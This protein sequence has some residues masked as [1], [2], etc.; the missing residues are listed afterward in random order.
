[1]NVPAHRP[2]PSGATEP[3]HGETD[4]GFAT[5]RGMGSCAA[6]RLAAPLIGVIRIYQWTLSPLLGP[7]CRHLPSC[8]SYAL[9]ALQRHGLI[10][11]SWLALRR[12]L[13]CQPW[14]TSGYDP[15]PPVWPCNAQRR[16]NGGLFRRRP[17]RGG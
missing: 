4:T 12:L 16:E 1:M 14:G 3:L 7:H 15:V 6:S 5:P 8:S 10:R 2:S 9:E 11:G 13:R 17:R